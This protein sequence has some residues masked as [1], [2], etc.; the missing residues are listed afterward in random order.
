MTFI[1]STCEDTCPLIAQQI[2][3]ALDDLG[4]RR[5][6]R[7]GQRRSGERHARRTPSASSSSSR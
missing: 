6:G 7:G 5:P 4:T 1:Y 2:R 3:G